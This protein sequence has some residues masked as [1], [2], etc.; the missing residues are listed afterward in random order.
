MKGLDTVSSMIDSNKKYIEYLLFALIV[1]GLMPGTLLGF[2]VGAQVK[3]AVRPLTDIMSNSI[4]QFVLFV[5]LLFTCCIK[6]DT[7]LFLLLAVF[8]II[9][10]R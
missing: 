5:L 7:N 2:N 3:S 10:R 4:V 1:I 9:T 8:L 6:K